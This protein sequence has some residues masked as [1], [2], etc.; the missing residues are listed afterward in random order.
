MTDKKDGPGPKES[1]AKAG[2]RTS[3]EAGGAKRPFATIDLRAV[4][5]SS[6]GQKPG[7]AA[8]KAAEAAAP[9][10]PPAA[11]PRTQAEAAAK[12]SAASAA[13]KPQGSSSPASAAGTPASARPAGSD[14]KASAAPSSPPPHE[15]ARKSGGGSFL[16]HA[17][18]GLIGAVVALAAAP[19]LTPVMQ[20]M[21]VAPP[22]AAS[23]EVAQRLAAVEKKIAQPPAAVD[24]ARDPAR[25]ISASEDNA[26]RL[27]ALQQQ[28]AAMS[29]AQARTAKSAADLEARLAKEPPIAEVGT[30]LV[31]LEQLLGDLG[32]AARDEPDRAGRIPQLALLTGR[33][34][35]LEAGLG[36]RIGEARKETTREIETRLAPVAEAS[37]AARATAQ[38]LDR[39]V[40]AL[41]SEANRLATDIDQAKTGAERLQLALKSTQDETAK[42][43]ASLEGVRREVE[44]RFGGVAKPADVAAA[45]A[46]LASQVT[47]LERNLTTVVKSET[48]RNATAER[49]VLSLE[50]GNLKRAMERGAPYARELAEVTKVAGP[51]IDLAPLQKYRDEGVPTIGE[52]T[53]SFRPIAHAVLDADAEKADGSVVDRLVS[54]AKTFVRVR[55]TTHASGDASPEAVVARIEDALRAGRLGDVLSEMKALPRKP[56]SSKNWLAK[57]EARHTVD[58]ALKSIDEALKASLSGATPPAAAPAAQKK[59]QP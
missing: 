44:T 38:R 36:T 41:K 8:S 40:G 21:G 2:D 20:Q 47:A 29:E 54:G 37:E 57:V 59:G 24:P 34:S 48:E 30:R 13:Q 9:K 53:R 12:V 56:D 26:K 22:P 1:P 23:P 31:G 52:L 3:S 4:D 15:Q 25:A 39:E 58:V 10:A 11:M 7:A 28:L 49:I 42:L 16:S 6:G 17:T 55:K 5:V 27:E 32:K 19:F 46:P 50:L 45:V 14:A 35:D 43:G 33:I 18:A 51:R